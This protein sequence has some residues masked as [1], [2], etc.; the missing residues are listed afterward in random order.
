M[1]RTEIDQSPPILII[2]KICDILAEYE[3]RRVPRFQC[4]IS[5]E[6][7]ILIGGF[8]DDC[9]VFDKDLLQVRYIRERG[10]RSRMHS[11]ATETD[12]IMQTL[13]ALIEDQGTLEAC[14]R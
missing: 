10:Q 4:P 5:K 2:L 1:Q 9:G 13:E 14:K 3:D 6:S 11:E 7:F 8:T 12:Q